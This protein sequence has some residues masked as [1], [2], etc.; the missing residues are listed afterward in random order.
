[1]SSV[2][3]ALQRL[4]GEMS[5]SQAQLSADLRQEMRL[6]ARTIAGRVDER[7]P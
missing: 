4:S 6:V 2:A 7:A 3:D 1:M 5:S